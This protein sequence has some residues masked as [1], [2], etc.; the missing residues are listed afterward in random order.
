[1]FSLLAT[2]DHKLL[3]GP[4]G[5]VPMVSPAK[6]FR[7]K[8]V[9]VEQH[10][11]M[12]AQIQKA[13]TDLEFLGNNL[14][15]EI[16]ADEA[17]TRNHDPAHFAYPTF[18]KAAIQRRENLKRSA[19]LLKIQSDATKKVLREINVELEAAMRLVGGDRIGDQFQQLSA[20]S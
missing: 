19:D 3:R 2:W 13:I 9:Q 11:R 5:D 18:A 17:R 12:I 14:N 20:A 16:S 4:R 1:M 7:L 6:L 15:H 8:A 10:R